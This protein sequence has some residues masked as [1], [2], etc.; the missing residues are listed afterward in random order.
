[1]SKKRTDENAIFVMDKHMTDKC[2]YTYYS[3]TLDGHVSYHWH[4]YF[5][6][7]YIRSGSA[8]HLLN[9]SMRL[10]KPGDFIFM[11][12]NDAH[13][14]F[15]D[16]KV[17]V[18]IFSFMP[19]FPDADIMENVLNNSQSCVVSLKKN[20]K[21]RIEGYLETIGELYDVNSD[22]NERYIKCLLSAVCLEVYESISQKGL[23]T[24]PLEYTKRNNRIREVLA[25]I[26]EHYMEE[27]T[28]HS[29]SEKFWLTPNYFS[30]F[31]R[32]YV[33]I[34]FS[35]YLTYI[36]VRHAISLMADEKLSIEDIAT[37]V[38]F[39]SPSYFSQA[40]KRLSGMS[41]KVYQ[42]KVLRTSKNRKILK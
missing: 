33:N 9:K 38:G 34:T 11:R 35:K 29:M 27:L 13:M 6:I 41:P 18:R 36:R 40:F 25:Y 19:S 17:S 5:E 21:R 28:L 16:T 12:P 20:S 32:E 30:E 42:T 14:F 24:P 37:M 7:T 26:D 10:L 22:S 3:Y 4:N 39:N 8:T 31:F 15:K 1:M 2:L 23:N